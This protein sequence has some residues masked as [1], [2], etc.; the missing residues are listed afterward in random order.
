M[1]SLANEDRFLVFSVLRTSGILRGPA[2]C[3]R[4]VSVPVGLAE[5]AFSLTSDLVTICIAF[6]N[7]GCVGQLGN[8]HTPS[9]LSS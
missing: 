3:V 2:F 6:G 4:G 9:A 5:T 1:I 7:H 8:T